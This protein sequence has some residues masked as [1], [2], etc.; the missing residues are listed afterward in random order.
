MQCIFLFKD[1]Q[2]RLPSA[3]ELSRRGFVVSQAVLIAEG[4][5]EAGGA[6][7]EGGAEHAE[8]LPL[9]TENP[10]RYTASGAPGVDTATDHHGGA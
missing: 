8:G 1:A 3:R 4:T 6:T 9:A 7:A 5:S 2:G 10:A